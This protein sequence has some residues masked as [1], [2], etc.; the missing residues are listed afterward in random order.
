MLLV[1]SRL[2]DINRFP[3]FTYLPANAVSSH[4]LRKISILMEETDQPP[5]VTE[6]VC[7]Y[8]SAG[9]ITTPD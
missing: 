2:Q 6:A 8:T 5:V 1:A 3:V 4:C 9:L 7:I